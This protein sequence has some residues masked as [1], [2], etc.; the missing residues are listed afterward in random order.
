M[1]NEQCIPLDSYF[2]VYPDLWE[3]YPEIVLKTQQIS[4]V[5]YAVPPWT[6]MQPMMFMR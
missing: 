4:G 5:Q 1:K 6:A 2:D 3:M